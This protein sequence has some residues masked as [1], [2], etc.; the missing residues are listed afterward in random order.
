[1]EGG[2]EREAGELDDDC[3]AAS[4]TKETESGQIE[5]DSDEEDDDVQ[6]TI[7]DIKT[8]A[9]YVHSFSCV[10]V[11]SE[12]IA[13]RMLLFGLS[14]LSVQNFLFEKIMTRLWLV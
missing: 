3:D 10:T 11:N 5:D 6:I 14:L 4:G 9:Q 2:E 13:N 8:G 12:N 7:G 1:M